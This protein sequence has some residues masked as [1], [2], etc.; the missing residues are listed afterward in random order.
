MSGASKGANEL[1]LKGALVYDGLGNPPS[2]ADLLI[3]NG[4][5][6]AV[7]PSLP[8]KGG[9]ELFDARGLSLAPGFID[10]HGHSDVSLLAAPEAFGKISQGVTTEISGNCGLSVFPATPEVRDHFKELYRQYPVDF[11]WS[12]LD[13]Y[14]KELERRAPAMNIAS[15]CGHNTLRACVCG[16]K[17]AP[18]G[19]A[20]LKA[21][22]K[23][24]SEELSK[25]A[26]GFSTGLI[27]VPGK[28]SSFEELACLAKALAGSGKPHTTHL[29]SEGACLLEALEEA[30]AISNAGGCRLHISHLKTS[31]KDNWGKLD[32]ALE[33]VAKFK[34]E[35][36]SISADRYPY[37]YS[38][39]SLSVALPA[40]FSDLDDV[41]LAEFLR[42]DSEYAALETAL[43]SSTRD[44]SL[45]ILA[46]TNAAFVKAFCGLSVSEI[47]AKLSMTP[48]RLV[49]RL[50]REDAAG[51]EGAFGGMCQANQDR[52]LSLPWLCCGSDESARP[53][54]YALGRSH[55]RGFGSFPRFLKAVAATQGMAEAIRRSTSL[56]AAIFGLKGRGRIVPGCVADLTLFN[57]SKLK[58]EATFAEPHKA[59]S[60]IEAVFVAGVLSFTPSGGSVGRAGHLLRL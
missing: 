55:P 9:V 44:W 47:S 50:M 20:K 43:L 21:M 22:S 60:G 46:S 18:C 35:G 30:V 31:G 53:Q 7:A 45:V 40:P 5:V 32:A 33:T 1:L 24:L 54:S 38:K 19:E 36:M 37:I 27:Y 4:L 34:R 56:P 52:I 49:A 23:L 28:F 58:D 42:E 15:L 6:K 26:A 2:Q 29:R 39:T 10:A 57:E 12:D 14:A 3:S 13:G 48:A 41:A 17:D 51:T 25:G 16:Y 11:T 59:S 8:E